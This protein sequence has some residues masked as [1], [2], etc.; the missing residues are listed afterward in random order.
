M[1]KVYSMI[2]LACKAGKIVS[3]E[4][5]V[6]N[7]IRSGK[8]NLLI[9][10]EDASENTKKRF[11]NAAAFYQ[12]ECRVWGRKEQLGSCMGK[13]ERS[14]IAVTDQGFD[15]ALRMR[16]DQSVSEKENPGGESFE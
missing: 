8:V 15:H 13:S 10:S 4:D 6:R 9:L 7:A 12:V 3:G 16:I 2:S 5:A 11:M 1:S 14:V